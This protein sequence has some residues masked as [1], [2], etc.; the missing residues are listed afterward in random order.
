[1]IDVEL[2][3]EMDMPCPC[4]RCGKWFDL[5]DGVGS[6]KWY[7]N[8]VICEDCGREEEKEIERDEQ[9]ED[10]KSSLEDAVYTVN[11]CRRELN[12][13]GIDVP[14]PELNLPKSFAVVQQPTVAVAEV[15][16]IE[17]QKDEQRKYTKVE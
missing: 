11:E 13:L 17:K 3:E 7:P 9:I 1:M 4:Q 5:N 15:Q 2:D 12:K 8:T 16:E 10:L 6:E 14:L